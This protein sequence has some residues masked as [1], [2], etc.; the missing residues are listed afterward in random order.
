MGSDDDTGVIPDEYEMRSGSTVNH[1]VHSG[2]RSGMGPSRPVGRGVRSPYTP[3][4]APQAP[5]SNSGLAK[6]VSDSR[7]VEEC[8][9]T[10]VPGGTTFSRRSHN[11]ED[12][13]SWAAEIESGRGHHVQPA[14][15][16]HHRK[17]D[18]HRMPVLHQCGLLVCALIL[19][20][21]LLNLRSWSMLHMEKGH[22]LHSVSRWW[23]DVLMYL[24]WSFSGVLILIIAALVTYQC[25]LGMGATASVTGS[26]FWQL[27]TVLSVINNALEPIKG[28]VLVALA[29]GVTLLV[30]AI[31]I[32]WSVVHD[33]EPVKEQLEQDLRTITEQQAELTSMVKTL[34]EQV[35]TLRGVVHGSPEISEV[36]NKIT[37]VKPYG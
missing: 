8:K 20:V 11:V 1:E 25:M 35:K 34:A 36:S 5:A 17:A 29:V 2:F 26:M 9:A 16:H 10:S 28:P 19:L 30:W 3:V 12:Q 7:D 18:E 33:M 15:S 23:N 13:E 32:K 27:G 6:G 4:R 22:R 24:F 14:S 31:A 21:M 37:P